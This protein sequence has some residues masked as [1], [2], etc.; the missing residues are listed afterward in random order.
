MQLQI[1]NSISDY[2][3]VQI[4]SSDDNDLTIHGSSSPI[5]AKKGGIILA[6]SSVD[7]ASP[8]N[9]LAN[10]WQQ[11]DLEILEQQHQTE[12]VMNTSA[13]MLKT[14]YKLGH[15]PFSKIKQWLQMAP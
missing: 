14:H 9:N 15:L 1:T 7:V 12:Q 11:K 8:T 5:S 13:L 10:N 2:F 6:K 3:N 4:V